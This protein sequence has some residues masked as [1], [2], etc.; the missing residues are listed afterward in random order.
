MPRL[1]VRVLRMR[2]RG[3]SQPS[4]RHRSLGAT[5]TLLLP[6]H[7]SKANFHTEL[8]A[9]P[10]RICVAA[11]DERDEGYRHPSPEVAEAIDDAT[12]SWFT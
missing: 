4:M 1:K 11:A 12:S 8:L 6:H 7:G 10:R 9:K 5:R 2:H 3:C